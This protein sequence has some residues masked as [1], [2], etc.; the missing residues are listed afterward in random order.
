[1]EIGA[2]SWPYA[3]QIIEVIWS[4]LNVLIFIGRKYLRFFY[5]FIKF[6]LENTWKIIAFSIIEIT[7]NLT[8]SW[9]R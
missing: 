2:V 6:A 3:V 1:M 4:I 9:K 7:F 8:I 5:G